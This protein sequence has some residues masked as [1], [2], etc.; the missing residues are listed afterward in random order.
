MSHLE[1]FGVEIAIAGVAFVAYSEWKKHH[2]KPHTEET[3]AEFQEYQANQILAQQQHH[4]N[5]STLD[6]KVA[7]TPFEGGVAS[8]QAVRHAIHKHDNVEHFKSVLGT[9]LKHERDR[10]RSR[11]KYQQSNDAIALFNFLM[12]QLEGAN[13][14]VLGS[15]HNKSGYLHAT[16]INAD[17]YLEV[18]RL[19][20]LELISELIQQ[21]KLVAM[22]ASSLVKTHTN[23]HPTSL[24]TIELYGDHWCQSN[25][26]KQ[27]QQQQFDP[28]APF[29]SV[30]TLFLVDDSVS[31]NQFTD[32]PTR[33][34]TLRNLLS[35][36][37]P[38][39]SIQDPY[40]VDLLFLN[41][42][43]I[44]SGI[45][46]S[47]WVKS[48]FEHV[49]EP[50]GTHTGRRVRDLLDAYSAVLRYDST[51]QPLN[52]VVFTDGDINDETLLCRTIANYVEKLARRGYAG[53][54]IGIEFVQIGDDEEAAEALIELE[55]VINGH[56]TKYSRHVV[57][58]T[59]AG[60][61]KLSPFNVLSVIS[62]GI[63]KRVNTGGGLRP[64]RKENYFPNPSRNMNANQ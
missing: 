29:S 49:G 60:R 26:Q 13:Y 33:W 2:N 19:F 39:I 40:G 58:I 30:R 57:G 6:Q 61:I 37:I 24:Q 14:Q 25:I 22:F 52:L 42:P 27:L 9:F 59:P 63:V 7:Y 15:S 55:R 56:H 8:Q 35:E 48:A 46:D 18:V 62:S 12:D 23:Q 16:E 53:H 44:L 28:S 64:L 31:M 47:D 43:S 36:I 17:Q 34:V 20:R 10:Q 11:M 32:D 21:N 3:R 45:K 54:Q 51:I 1:R 5:N 50:Q 38:Q 41:D 4:A